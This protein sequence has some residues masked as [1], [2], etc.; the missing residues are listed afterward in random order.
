[1]GLCNTCWQNKETPKVWRH[2]HVSTIFKKGDTS[3]PSNYR[4]ISLLAVGYKVLASLLLARL[5]NS[6]VE[7]RLRKTQ[8]GFRRH[9]GSTDAVFLAQR[10]IDQTWASKNGQLSIVRL[11]WAK[12]FDRVD[13]AAMLV[14][15]RR[16][17][18][19]VA[20]VDMIAGI[21]CNRTFVVKAAEHP[22][23]IRPQG[24]GIAQGCPLSPYLFII[25]LSVLLADVDAEVV[26]H[27][28]AQGAVATCS[29]ITYADDVALASSTPALLQ[30]KLHALISKALLYGL[31]PNWTKTVHLPV[32]HAETIMMPDGMPLKE[33][34]TAVYLGSLL[35]TRGSTKTVIARR[36]GEAKGVL[37]DL[38]AV[39]RHAN[40]TK[41]RKLEIFNACVV[42]KLLYSLETLS[43]RAA[44]WSRIDA[45]HAQSLRK[46]TGI[47]HSMLSHIS[48]AEVWRI[49]AQRQL[50]KTLLC[51][52]L[53]LFGKIAGM[54]DESCMRSAVFV[55]ASCCPVQ[56]GR[57]GRGRPR[58]RWET[59]L[60]AHAL[61]ILDDHHGNLNQ[62][63]REVPH[64]NHR[65][66]MAVSRYCFP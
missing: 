44:D 42:S 52:Q 35:T 60:H 57:R 53:L 32:R 20:I 45:F 50:S 19:P 15:L 61:E 13:P 36:I 11:D 17:G 54:P 2:A 59:T 30:V 9:K 43:F 34:E 28:L 21:Y 33:V 22:S 12:A 4:P 29:D 38:Q 47:P 26:Q 25:M 55:P 8:F 23:D 5:A 18:L 48:N 37:K 6:G 24:A 27:P 51:R 64:P 62:M 16:F 41:R 3:L 31:E 10:L 14:A 7:Q 58:L 56:P 40:L 46:I 65:W 39:W 49:S 1:M 63:L 66:K